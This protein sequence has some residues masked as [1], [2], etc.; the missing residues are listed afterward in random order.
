MEVLSVA[1]DSVSA[2][3]GTVSSAQPQPPPPEP[4][5]AP[6]VVQESSTVSEYA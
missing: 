6:Q 5:P 3:L 1:A 4:Q 2:A